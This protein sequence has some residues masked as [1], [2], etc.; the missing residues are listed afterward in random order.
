MKKSPNEK[1]VKEN[2]K[3]YDKAIKKF[4]LSSSSVL[5]DDQQSQ[6]FRFCEL[7][8]HLDLSSK[9][10]ILDV[11]CGN[12]ELYKFLNFL[13]FRGTYVGSDINAN[14]I[15]QAKKRFPA[16]EFH[17]VDIME[18]KIA[19]KFDYALMS[20]LF[21]VN[22]N[23]SLEWTQKFVKKMFSLSREAIAFNAISTYVNYKQ[24]E[25]FYLSPEEMFAYCVKNLSPRV[26]L[27]HHNLPYNYTIIVYKNS[28]WTSANRKAKDK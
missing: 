25:M 3:I 26:T 5:W 7:V 17:L 9:K 10:S 24:D 2:I 20:G 14:L 23:Q 11:G 22:V 18:K 6:Y 15:K 1:F 21:N 28:T 8:K 12:G 4:G 19:R 27:L 16:V 13:G